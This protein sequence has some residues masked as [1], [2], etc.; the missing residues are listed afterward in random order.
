MAEETKSLRDLFKER[1]I[2]FDFS[3]LKNLADSQITYPQ[4]LALVAQRILL[5]QYSAQVLDDSNM[6]CYFS[7]ASE[8][9]NDNKSFFG[10][11]L[12]NLVLKRSHI[13][14]INA[15]VSG[16]KVTEDEQRD[17][18]EEFTRWYES[19]WFYRLK[20]EDFSVNLE[21]LFEDSFPPSIERSSSD[22]NIL[23]QLYK[24]VDED[25]F[26]ER[27]NIDS[28]IL[29]NRPNSVS[30]DWF[31]EIMEDCL[32][33]MNLTGEVDVSSFKS[34]IT[35]QSFISPTIVAYM[36]STMMGIDELEYGTKKYNS[37][38]ETYGL[39]RLFKN[40]SMGYLLRMNQFVFTLYNYFKIIEK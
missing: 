23:S 36:T 1:E 14:I 33:F 13:A 40:T 30:P 5:K 6:L 12:K 28:K 39:F 31:Y 4:F 9:F 37:P 26:F 34:L 18:A 22:W 29:I 17:V 20:S 15:Q 21:K 8:I 19:S 35:K 25:E 24:A 16:N 27:L 11:N 38:F 32:K 7:R 10:Q 3:N 2:S